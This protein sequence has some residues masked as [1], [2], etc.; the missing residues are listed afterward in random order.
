MFVYSSLLQNKINCP[1]EYNANIFAYIQ[2]IKFYQ[3]NEED[4]LFE[5]LLLLEKINKHNDIPLS[6][7]RKFYLDILNIDDKF[8]WGINLNMNEK[9]II[10][11]KILGGFNNVESSI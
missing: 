7:V 1:L 9:E 5:K 4:I 3:K 2:G 6:E 10:K 8:N 11:K